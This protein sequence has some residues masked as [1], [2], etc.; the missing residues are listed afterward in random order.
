MREGECRLALFGL[1]AEIFFRD[2]RAGRVF[3]GFDQLTPEQLTRLR[4]DQK[5]RIDAGIETPFLTARA[6]RTETA[7]EAFGGLRG[8]EGG[9]IDP[10]RACLG[11]AAAAA[12]RNVQLFERSAV[13]RITFTRNCRLMTATR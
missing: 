10:Y 4:K 9:T 5:A 8:R 11:L 6:T 13:R 2:V 12:E 7:L 3:V 1:A